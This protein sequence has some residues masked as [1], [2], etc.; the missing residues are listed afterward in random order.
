MKFSE[1]V[2]QT[3]AWLRREGRVSYRALRLEFDLTEDVLDALKEELIEVKELAVD[4]DG[5]MLVWIGE[6][7]KGEAAKRGKGEESLASRVQRPES[8]GQ[9]RTSP[10]QTLDPRPRDAR[11]DA[12]ERRQLTVMF[13][14]LVDST[15]LSAQ[16]DP[17]EYREVVRVYQQTCAAVIDYYEGHIAQHLGD[18]LLVYFGY[19]TA[20][21]DDV[22]SAVRAGLGIVE[23]IQRL[24]FLTIQLPHPVQ[25]RIG[26]HT[27]L[28]VV[29]EI[30]SSEKREMLALGETPNL[31][32]R[33]QGLSEPD[34]VVIS[35]ATHRLIEGLLDCRDLGTH[36]VKGVSTPLQVY[37]V[38]GES[39]TRSRLEAAAIRGLTPLVGRE[40]ESEL[41]RKRWEQ[42]KTGEGQVVLLSGE[43]GIGKSRLVQI[44][45]EQI[46]HEPSVRVEY[47]CS[48][49]H[50]NSAFYPV[51]DHFLR[52]L[53]VTREDSPEDKLR[54]LE[55]VFADGA[56]QNV[57]RP[58]EVVALLAS[59][60]SLPLPAQ[61]PP[62]TL[63]PQRQKQRTLEALVA[64]L[65]KEAERQPV[66]VVVEDVHWVD[67]STLEFLSLLLDQVP[68]TRLLLLLTFRPDFTPPWAM[69]SHITQL[70][71][72]RLARRQ[73]EE[74][75]EKVTKGKPL[76]AEV[77]QQLV[78]K[79][80]GVPL[81]VEELT[82][83]VLESGSLEV[84]E[85]RGALGQS[86]ML[87]VPATL[88]DALMARLDRLATVK[89]VAQL[90]AVLGREFSYEVI[91]TLTAGDAP[92]LQQA[93]AK[94]IEAEIL[95]QR[96]IGEQARYFFK[97]ALIQ[98]TAYQSL[99]K[100]TRQQYHQQ[101]AH[102]L[103]Q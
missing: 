25:V 101:I 44:L 26:V 32:A 97:H 9:G 78:T 81:F 79:T 57:P 91:Q 19:P 16:L 98:D 68:T 99:L 5:K 56:L 49:Y 51:I 7:V 64:W 82:K 14:D 94:L 22:Q 60:L 34:A 17:E 18:G 86:V 89:E 61:Y 102:V 30:G 72:S 15:A 43:A 66:L 35:T 55:A 10:V 48:P 4:K 50:Q 2:A 33:L 88:Q 23:A 85:S 74:M 73:V 67:P 71:L 87:G 69:F 46:A 45:K 75:V 63:T 103:E 62:L 42:A 77:I 6:G 3:L 90:G 92:S 36:A 59:L 65:V 53:Q 40:E 24:S 1:V 96:G 54:K 39:A 83:T 95:Y 12:G 76:P 28:V 21:E 31:A 47:R 11:L 13:C 93:L 100:S 37:Q 84:W 41:L 52:L 27:G 58:A 80:D 8:E 38:V 29:G 70:T 20:H